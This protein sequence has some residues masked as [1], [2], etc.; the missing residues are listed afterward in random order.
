MHIF[1]ILVQV[2]TSF[3]VNVRTMTIQCFPTQTIKIK[4][5]LNTTPWGSMGE[6]E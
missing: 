1:C 5:C 6:A 4:L 3:M 2:T